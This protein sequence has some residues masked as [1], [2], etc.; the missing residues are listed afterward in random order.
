MLTSLPW[1][2]QKFTSACSCA[3]ICVLLWLW[4]L[5]V[6]NEFHSHDLWILVKSCSAFSSFK[7]TWQ[8][9]KWQYDK[10]ELK[11]HNSVNKVQCGAI[12]M[13]WIFPKNPHNRHPMRTRYGVS[14]MSINYDLGNAWITAMLCGM[15]LYRKVS[16]ISRTKSQNLNDSRL[17]LHLFLPN[18]LKPGVK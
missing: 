17:V 18:L 14:F 7:D 8:E 3:V 16:N 1:L 15:G 10:F 5:S 12:I 13:L 11:R 9:N 4:R 2:L 6:I